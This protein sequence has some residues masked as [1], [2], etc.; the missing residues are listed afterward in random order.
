VAVLALVVPALLLADPASHLQAVERLFELTQMREKIEESVDQ[1]LALQL[2]QNPQLAAHRGTVRAFLDRQI[3]WDALREP[4]VGMYV[5]AFSEQEL[6]EMNA[7]YA[8]PTGQKVIVR[9]PDLVQ[10]RNQLAMRRLQAHIGELQAAIAH[11][12]GGAEKPGNQ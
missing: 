9:L 11:E 10:E 2:R 7:F 1:V 5:A 8:S 3:G 6:S 12:T 4:L